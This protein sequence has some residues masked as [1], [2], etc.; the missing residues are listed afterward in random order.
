VDEVGEGAGVG[1]NLNVPL[2]MGS[3][4]HAYMAAF[5][6]LVTPAVDTFAPT[7][8]VVACG[9]DGSCVDPLGRMLL[10]MSGFFGLGKRCRAL[11]DKH[12]HGRLVATLEGGYSLG[13]SAYCVDAVL[14]ALAGRDCLELT[15]PYCG[16]YPDPPLRDPSGRRNAALLQRLKVDREAA[17][18]ALD[19]VK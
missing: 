2:D 10:T 17:I 6:A 8:V 3:G 1:Y 12:A 14:E 15:D 5:D 7:F 4:D 19:V 16:A 11:A 18:A 9:V 13:Y